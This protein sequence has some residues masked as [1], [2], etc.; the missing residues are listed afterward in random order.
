M[1]SFF[2]PEV[3]LIT[4]IVGFGF[5]ALWYSPILFIKAWMKGLGITKDNM[6][7][8]SSKYKFQIY[9]YSFVAHGAMATTLSVI[10]ELVQVDTLK[11]ALSLGLLLG[12]G[13]IVTTR[14]IDMVYTVSGSHYEM[15]PQLNFLVSGGYYASLMAIMSATMFLV[16]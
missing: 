9:S 2:T 15:R 11:S 12:I 5:G 8:R 14:F 3:I 16:A 10:F 6:P 1:Q 7:Y 13:F 4:T